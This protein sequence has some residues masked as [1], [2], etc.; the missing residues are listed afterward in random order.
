MI[1]LKTGIPGS[2]KTLTAVRELMVR[3]AKPD[4]PVVFVHGIPNL[5]LAVCPLPV[6]A[7]VVNVKGNS[8]QAR[9]QIEVDWSVVPDGATI[10]IDEAQ[11]IFPPR[12]SGAA[13]PGYV[14]FLN[15]HRH[16]GIDIVLITQDPRLVDV[17]VRALVGKHQHYRRM[18]GGLRHM[19]YEWDYCDERLTGFKLA[20]KSVHGFPK[21]AF[22]AYKSAEI[23]TRQSFSKPAWLLVPVIAFAALAYVGPKGYDVLTKNKADQAQAAAVELE[24]K[25]APGTKGKTP[26]EL[27]AAGGVRQLAPN[28]APVPA[29]VV[30]VAQT[31]PPEVAGCWISDECVCVTNESR[32]RMLRDLGMM[33]VDIA[34]GRLAVDPSRPRPE[35]APEA[36]QRAAAPVGPA[37]A[38]V[39]LPGLL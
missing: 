27:L 1:T 4:I 33:C 9:N 31:F 10:I 14:S 34:H 19:R 32:P 13:V 38:S 35:R 29:G 12:G 7:P 23:H 15:T 39:G 2:G 11:H 28:P 17:T 26:A 30:L 16:R 5:S 22:G 20:T 21:K 37:S 6:F 24:P 18:F 36:T 8:V 25:H 3:L